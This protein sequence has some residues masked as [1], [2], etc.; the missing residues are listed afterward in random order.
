MRTVYIAGPMTGYIDFNYP[1]F[2]HASRVWADKGWAVLNPADH[3]LRDQRL[4]MPVYMRGA[5]HAVLQADALA[6]LP[7]WEN[8]PG[9]TMEVI[10]AHRLGL[11]IYDAITGKGINVA[12]V[13]YA[14]AHR[15]WERLEV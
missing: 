12:E 13:C 2:D 11:E 1:A 7:G 8:S 15:A 6:L 10:L 4:D 5:I 3:F 14:D 9:A